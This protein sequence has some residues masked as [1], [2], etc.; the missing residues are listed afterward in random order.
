M[1]K[2]YFGKTE[3]AKETR[4]LLVEIINNL[5]NNAEQ[6]MHTSWRMPDDETRGLLSAYADIINGIASN[7]YDQ[8]EFYG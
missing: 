7:L 2:L 1:L 6:I 3:S 4:R 8:F 5:Q